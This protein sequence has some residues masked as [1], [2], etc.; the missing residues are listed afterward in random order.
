[1][2]LIS[3]SNRQKCPTQGLG[4]LKEEVNLVFK[5]KPSKKKLLFADVKLLDSEM[6]SGIQLRNTLNAITGVWRVVYNSKKKTQV[7]TKKSGINF[8]FEDEKQHTYK[9]PKNNRG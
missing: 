9:V 3:L 5:V 7:P 6:N 8:I 2:S 1:M 4:V